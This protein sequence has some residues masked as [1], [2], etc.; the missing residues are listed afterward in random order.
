MKLENKV[1]LITGSASGMGKGEAIAFA[2]EGAK[3][4]V[5]DLNKEAAEEVV[6]EIENNNGQ[7]LAIEV[8]LTKEDEVESMIKQAK[9]KFGKIDILVNN[10]GVFDKYQTSLDTPLDKWN[11]LINVNL[12]SVFNVTNQV[13]PEMIE[14]E[15]GTIVN[16]ASIAGIV[17]GKGGAAYT[18]SKH[19]VIGLTKHLASE[20]AKHGIQINAIAPGTIETPLIKEVKDT[21]PN[22]NIPAR[23]FGEVEEV[24]ELAIFLSSDEAR[25]I[26][27]TV[28]PIDG[29]FTIQ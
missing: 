4:I 18:T 19:G 1:A 5:A 23:R 11:F 8:D 28:V 22:D 29:G 9:D 26:N 6:K 16:I 15:S 20:Y 2:R 3:V 13:L 27:G 12:T 25:F 14:R 7:A 21:I 24:A 17:A 10:A